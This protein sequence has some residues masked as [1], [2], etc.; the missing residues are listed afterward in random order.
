M[1]E[2]E[3][4]LIVTDLTDLQQRLL[5]HGVSWSEPVEQVD[6]YFQHPC[7][8]FAE[9]GEALRLRRDG[10][11]IFLTYKGPKLSGPVKTRR[12]IEIPLPTPETTADHSSQT[13]SND[14][15]QL[16][17]SL[18]FKAFATVRKRRRSAKLNYLQRDIIL[19]LDEVQHLGM[20]LE[21][22]TLAGEHELPQA[23]AVVMQLAECLNVRHVE[24]RSYLRMLL[25]LPDASSWRI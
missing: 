10:E 2:V 11:E 7:R 8:D 12:E 19:A 13:T 23:H 3:Q 24:P 22:E 14:L 9:T 16:L 21:I 5:S 4:K 15:T 20:F 17:Q 25:S 1:Y 18:G 6:C